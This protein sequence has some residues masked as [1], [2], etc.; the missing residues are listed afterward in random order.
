MEDIEESKG[1]GK[2]GD[3]HNKMIRECGNFLSDR[4]EST[5]YNFN[6]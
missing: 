6:V 4:E 3:S 1:G 2:H 5:A